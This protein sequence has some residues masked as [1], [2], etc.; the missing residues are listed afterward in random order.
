MPFAAGGLLGG[1]STGLVL[2]VLSG[3]T[4]P[5]PGRARAIAVLGAAV[6]LT[7]LDLWQHRLRLPQRGTLIPQTVFAAG[8]PRGFLRFGFEYGTGVR[9]LI[10]SAAS[11]ILAAALVLT[12]LPWWQTVLVGAVFGFSRTLAV[13]QYLLMGTDDWAAFL[14]AHTRVLERLGS[15]VAAGLVSAAALPAVLG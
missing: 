6:V 14:S 9:T 13:L 3:L 11:Y 5:L 7:A 10:P 2:A 1:A 12:G 15:L 8:L 4:S